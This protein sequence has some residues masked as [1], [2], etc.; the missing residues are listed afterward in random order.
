[1]LEEAGVGCLGC[2]VPDGIGAGSVGVPAEVCLAP[3]G[4]DVIWL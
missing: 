3:G 2:L 4:D 1:M